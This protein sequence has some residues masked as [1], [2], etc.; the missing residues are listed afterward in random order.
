MFDV[1]ICIHEQHDK[2]FVLLA[3]AICVVSALCSV[4]LLRHARH[5]S[6]PAATRWILGAGSAI[7]FGVWATHF[8]AM[9]G[10][11][12]GLIVGYHVPATVIS[13]FTVVGM[14]SL[15]FV[16]SLAQPHRRGFVLAGVI[17]GSGI[18]AMHYIGMSA[19]EFPAEINW[20][21]GYVAVSILLAVAPAIPALTLSVKGRTIASAVPAAGLLALSIVGLH[22]TGMAAMELTP[23]PLDLRGGALLSPESMAAAISAGSLA[24]LAISIAVLSIA[25]SAR[26]AL[27]ATERDMSIL[28]KGITDCAIY[29]L[30]RKGNVVNWNAGAQRLK[31][32]TAQ[33]AVGLPLAAFYTP[34]DQAED[35][36]RRAVAHAA[37]TGK[38]SGEGWRMRRDGTRF[39]AHVT[40]ER[41]ANEL[42]EH[43]GFA[44]L[45]RDMTRFKED[46]DRVRE[47]A[48][49]LD[50]ALANMHQGLCLFD[51][52]GHLLIANRRFN[53]IW[54]IS[55]ATSLTGM[56]VQAVADVVLGAPAGLVASPERRRELRRQFISPAAST[57]PVIID[58]GDTVVVSMTS[59]PMP[60]GGRVATFDDITERRRSE[61]KIAHMARHDNLTG[62]PNR[63]SFAHWVDAELEEARHFGHQLAVVMID[64]DRFKEI[65]DT[66]G[67]SAGDAALQHLAQRM[68]DVLQDGEIVARLG[69]DEFAAAV[70][71]RDRSELDVFL[72]RIEG[73]FGTPFGPNDNDFLLGGSIGVAVYPE[74][75]DVREQL[76]N[77]ADLAMY[78][79]KG[80]VA[81]NIAFYEPEMDETA[82]A[83]RQ[84][85]NDLRHAIERNEFTLL[86]QPQ[87]CIATG[88]V[89][90]YE[91]LL[92]WH[93]PTRGPVSPV[94]FIPVAEETGEI[95]RIGEWVMREACREARS[96]PKHLKV[97]VNL[98]AVQLLQND[99]VAIVQNILVETGLSPLRLELEITETAIIAD[100]LRALHFLR[101]IKTLG[102]SIAIDDFGTGYSSLDTLHSFPFDKIKIDKSFVL[103]SHESVEA[104]AIIKAVLA[105]GHSLN[106]PV[107]AEGVETIEQ[108][109]LLRDQ[110]CDEAQGFYF[111]RPGGSPSQTA[112]SQMMC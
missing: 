52:D 3:A 19:I 83:R 106:V 108:L 78:R 80:S 72:A 102:V 60:D 28:V 20:R 81:E 10:Y 7:G 6:G 101:Q 93:H 4:Q 57:A 17:A 2:W 112:D 32:Y 14:T 12:P 96:W 40:I 45:T 44:K 54:G 103:R 11:G 37:E 110:G 9:L 63:N 46:E 111:G 77:N 68:V 5:L 56:N 62:L 43:I 22:F 104:C 74:D 24:L 65:N 31:G 84:I 73:C 13:L 26:L 35:L 107:L 27:H 16:V 85:A 30:D 18:S 49:H 33:E 75:G 39:W 66:R 25:R 105:L 82:R 64:L 23:A 55:P 92:R 99:F 1:L 88:K 89:S 47:M 95:F 15:S 97:A 51:A 98:S 41:V 29:M 38:F 69:G 94:E 34:E 90:G 53:A 71:F 87:H 100:K 42:G 59:R 91:A 21:A 86:Y 58:L 48:G 8:I 76:L 70:R 79:A 36:P 109:D 61:A 50:A 67:H